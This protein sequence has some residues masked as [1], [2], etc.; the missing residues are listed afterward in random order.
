MDENTDKGYVTYGG[1]S[2]PA[3]VEEM[4]KVANG[5]QSGCFIFIHNYRSSNGELADYWLHY[6]RDYTRIKEKLVDRIRSILQNKE[7]FSVDVDYLTWV[8]DKG[9]EH[10]VEAKGRILR[11]VSIRELDAHD[12]DVRQSLHEMFRSYG[13]SKVRRSGGGSGRFDKQ[14]KGI[15]IERKTNSIYF[16]MSTLA[17]KRIIEPPKSPSYSIRKSAIKQAVKDK[18]LKIREFKLGNFES[19]SIGGQKILGDVGAQG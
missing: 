16:R 15:Y 7:P 14:A 17:I 4:L 6:G 11:P 9:E 8:D 1:A 13:V 12:T 2:I 3:N 19:I 10:A 18:L 5:L